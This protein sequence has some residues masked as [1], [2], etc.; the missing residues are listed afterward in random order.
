MDGMSLRHVNFYG[1][2]VNHLLSKQ[3]LVNIKDNFM[4]F[5]YS[6]FYQKIDVDDSNTVKVTSKTR[7]GDK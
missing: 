5:K 6:S 4:L 1:R 2:Y 7:L 3:A